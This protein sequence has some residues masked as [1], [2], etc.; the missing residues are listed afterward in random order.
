VSAD[1]LQ[2]ALDRYRDQM[3]AETVAIADRT[4]VNVRNNVT[5]AGSCAAGAD[6]G[7]W[8]IEGSGWTTLCALWNP[9]IIRSG[10]EPLTC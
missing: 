6:R 2:A 7:P 1:N 8:E 10:D 3:A 5:L 4:L 9:L